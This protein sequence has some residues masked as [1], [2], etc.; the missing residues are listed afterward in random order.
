MIIRAIVF[1]NGVP[2][3]DLRR[4]YKIIKLN[5]KGRDTSI[6]TKTDTN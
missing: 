4:R 3:N 6:T 2:I 1:T 5:K